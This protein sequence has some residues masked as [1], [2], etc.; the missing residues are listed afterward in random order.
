M[1]VTVALR[2]EPS[3]GAPDLDALA[4]AL[5]E[6]ARPLFIGRKPCLP[7]APLFAGFSEGDGALGALLEWP[8]IDDRETDSDVRAIWP[9]GE[10][11]SGNLAGAD[12]R[13]HR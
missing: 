7:T 13:T 3:A 5:L 2:L 8:L 6:P 9:D 1:I 4:S 10:T 12:I 11:P